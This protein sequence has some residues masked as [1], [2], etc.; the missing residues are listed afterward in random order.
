MM[1]SEILYDIQEQILKNLKNKIVSQIK[2]LFY[3]RN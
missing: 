3:K 2:Q 1:L